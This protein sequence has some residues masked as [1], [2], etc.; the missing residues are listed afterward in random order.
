MPS[1]TAR[2]SCSRP[3][4][5]CQPTIAP[6]AAPFQYGLMTPL[7]YGTRTSPSLPA[8]TSRAAAS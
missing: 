3:C 2:N 7:K 5:Q 4:P 6:V 8:G 1:S